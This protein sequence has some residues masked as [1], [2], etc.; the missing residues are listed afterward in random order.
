VTVTP[1]RARRTFAALLAL[2]AVGAPPATAAVVPPPTLSGE[3]FLTNSVTTSGC[4]PALGFSF[5]TYTATGTASGPYPGKFSESGIV[6]IG[7]Q[8]QT[9]PSGS[10]V[11]LGDILG[12]SADFT[13][14][15]GIRVVTG[16]K[17]LL[18]PPPNPPFAGLL[19]ACADNAIGNCGTTCL[20]TKIRDATA[21]L[22]YNAQIDGN[23]KSGCFLDDGS[24]LGTV[25][26]VVFARPDDV[27]SSSTFLE[28]FTSN[29]SEVEKANC[30]VK[31]PP[32]GT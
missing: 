12:L 20:I 11:P 3:G 5:F 28:N 7:Q 27:F 19:G 18:G 10:V 22:S 14:S 15:S 4:N 1:S 23:G 29:R 21:T 9:P 6:L 31:G 13:I 26:D 2:A 17:D 32:P 16:T 30:K 25:Q 8:N 24:A